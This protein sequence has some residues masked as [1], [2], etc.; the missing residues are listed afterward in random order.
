MCFDTRC[1]ASSCRRFSRKWAPLAGRR[2]LEVEAAGGELVEAT[3]KLPRGVGLVEVSQCIARFKRAMSAANRRR[4]GLGY[5]AVFHAAGRNGGGPHLHVMGHSTRTAAEVKAILATAW[6]SATG[7][8]L[9]LHCEPLRDPMAFAAYAFRDDAKGRAAAPQVLKRGGPPAM[10]SNRLF[11]GRGGMKAAWK[12]LRL[13]RHGEP[14]AEVVEPS[15]EGGVA[16]SDHREQFH[17]GD[18]GADPSSPAPSPPDRSEPADRPHRIPRE[19]EPPPSVYGGEGDR[20]Q[21][22]GR[23]NPP[24]EGWSLDAAPRLRHDDPQG[25]RDVG[26]ATRW[27]VPGRRHGKG[28]ATSARPRS[29]DSAARCAVGESPRPRP[30]TAP[31]PRSRRGRGNYRLGTWERLL[32]APGRSGGPPGRSLCPSAWAMARPPPPGGFDWK[33]SESNNTAKP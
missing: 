24:Q 30:R 6:A 17:P 32:E 27:R 4:A 1:S 25:W 21:P 13:K 16:D 8:N 20:P 3:L 29:P 26:S 5:V 14:V 7:E 28:A 31:E 23:R 18:G 19:P 10:V 33:R 12:A 11:F 2:L 22:G 15:A 9:P